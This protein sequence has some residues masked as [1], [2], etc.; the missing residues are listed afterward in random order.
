MKRK[1]LEVLKRA[2]RYLFAAVVEKLF[3][4]DKLSG[5]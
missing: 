2:A 5:K 4:D 1:V 3:K